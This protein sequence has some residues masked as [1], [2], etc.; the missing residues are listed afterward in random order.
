MESVYWLVIL[1]ALMYEPIFGYFDFQRFKKE[2]KNNTNARIQYYLNCL[3]SLWVPTLFIF[4]VVAF[5]DLTFAEIGV[6][7]PIIN[8]ETFGPVITYMVFALA[9]IYLIGILYYRIGYAFSEKI[10]AKLTEAKEKE[11]KTTSF[12]V[13]LPETVKEKR[14]WNYVSL[15]AGITEEVIYRGFLVFALSFLFP[16]Q[17]IW[18]VI[19]FASFL[20]GLAHTYQ[21]IMGVVRTTIVGLFFSIL[22]I[23]LGSIL[24]LIILHFLVDYIA[25]FGGEETV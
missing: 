18:L 21:G 23:G 15:T 17:S 24:P 16:E 13:I 12:F 7:L 22:Y 1:F 10:R 20:F 8:I 5:S 9:L 3:V 25:K 4:L 6:K 19:F 14:L 2:V 11:I